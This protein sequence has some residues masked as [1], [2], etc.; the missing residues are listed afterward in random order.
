MYADDALV[1]DSFRIDFHVFITVFASLHSRGCVL[2]GHTGRLPS[3]VF[4]RTT[5][6][7]EHVCQ[8]CKLKLNA[9][10]ASQFSKFRIL[11]TRRPLAN[12]QNVVVRRP[13]A[14]NKYYKRRWFWCS[15]PNTVVVN[16]PSRQQFTSKTISF[17]LFLFVFWIYGLD[18]K[19]ACR[20]SI[21]F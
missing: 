11:P 17:V 13:W 9:S 16:K 1:R 14:H 4:A 15:I 2:V 7:V 3:C 10:S 6:N 8:L 12:I 18:A 20:R 19:L 5:L 21:G